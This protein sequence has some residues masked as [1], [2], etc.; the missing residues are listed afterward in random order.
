MRV[1]HQ[2]ACVR[3]CAHICISM[4]VSV[5]E[6]AFPGVFTRNTVYVQR[7]S[8]VD[9]CT[10][11][12]PLAV[13]AVHIA[14]LNDLYLSPSFFFLNCT[15]DYLSEPGLRLHPWPDRGVG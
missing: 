1:L 7:R 8:E 3:G 11:P 15:S 10:A 4:C 13:T 5:C 9:D 2:V 14:V 6:C 12:W